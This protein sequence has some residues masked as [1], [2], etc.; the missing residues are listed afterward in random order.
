MFGKD[1]FSNLFSKKDS[2]FTDE[3]FSGDALEAQTQAPEPK[4][5]TKAP[6]GFD[7]SDMQKQIKALRTSKD[8][9][10]SYYRY[11]NPVLEKYYAG[12]NKAEDKLQKGKMINVTDLMSDRYH[13]KG[14]IGVPSKDAGGV[15]A[16]TSGWTGLYT[17]RQMEKAGIDVDDK[18]I[19]T[20]M[21]ASTAIAGIRYNPE[22]KN[23]YIKFKGGKGK[24]YLFPN[25]PEEK[26]RRMLNAPSKGVYY[27][28]KIKPYAVSAGEAMAIAKRDKNK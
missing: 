23:L 14:D 3:S 11:D 15:N 18:D 2:G 20:S 28:K 1:F 4:K 9:R 5:T 27:G 10:K 13:F 12:I 19:D 22:T 21:I 17:K 8:G 25:V 16:K 24:E 26:V 7:W 6:A